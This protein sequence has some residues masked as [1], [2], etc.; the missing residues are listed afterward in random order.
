MQTDV[1]ASWQQLLEMLPFKSWHVHCTPIYCRLVAMACRYSYFGNIQGAL[2]TKPLPHS[3][4]DVT[5]GWLVRVSGF[6]IAYCFVLISS[7]L[8]STN[9]PTPPPFSFSSPL[10]SLL[11]VIP[12]FLSSCLSAALPGSEDHES[13]ESPK[14][15]WGSCCTVFEDLFCIC[16]SNMKNI[17]LT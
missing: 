12:S 3:Y 1:I 5:S 2:I 17:C 4:C 16:P 9:P 11:L 13:P 8:F 10:S 6:E 14:H 15:R 7:F